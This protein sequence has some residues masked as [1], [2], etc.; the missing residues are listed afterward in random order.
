MKKLL[1]VVALALM[2]LTMSAQEDS[3]ITVKAGVGLSSVV[4]SDADT[5]TT[6][7]YKV[8]I[9]YDLGLSEKFSI[10]PGVELSTKGFKSDVVDGSISMAYLQV[11]VFAAYKFPISDNMKLAIKAGPYVSYGLY[12]S[13]IEWY[14]G[15]KSNVFDSDGGFKRFDAGVIAGVSLDFNQFV[16]GAEYS[17]GLT[18]LDSDYSMFNQ[19]FG[20]VLGYKF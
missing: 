12:G 18:K 13:D 1:A 2:T 10:I 5:K 17:R 7:A 9:S 19:A 11:P 16:I 4:G 20:V 8:G 3:K 15:G 6:V 14:D